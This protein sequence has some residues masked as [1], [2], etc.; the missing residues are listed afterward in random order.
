MQNRI[1]YR[2]KQ[3]GTLESIKSFTH[4]ELGAKYRVLLNPAELSYAIVEDRTQRVFA[5]GRAVSMH[6]VKMSAKQA[7]ERLGIRFKQRERRKRTKPVDTQ[8]I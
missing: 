7:L 5:N 3:D 1:R 6:Y 4:P 2:N 8:T